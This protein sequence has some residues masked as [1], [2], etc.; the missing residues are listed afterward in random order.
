MGDQ[1]SIEGRAVMCSSAEQHRILPTAAHAES[2][3]MNGRPVCEGHSPSPNSSRTAQLDL[4]STRDGDSTQFTLMAER[5]HAME[6]VVTNL[7][8]SI[9]RLVEK[10]ALETE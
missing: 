5:F 3:Q 10:Q 8:D 6:G 1:C 7:V 2:K 9:N 4:F